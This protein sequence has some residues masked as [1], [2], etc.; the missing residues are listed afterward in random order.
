M[1]IVQYIN[2]QNKTILNY[3]KKSNVA[4]II[5]RENIFCLNKKE[6]ISKPL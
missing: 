4:S 1:H 6:W 3:I 2:D 5:E